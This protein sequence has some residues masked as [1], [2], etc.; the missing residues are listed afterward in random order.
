[1]KSVYQA[2][3]KASSPKHRK[4]THTPSKQQSKPT[5]GGKERA[6]HGGGRRVGY[7]MIP[8]GVAPS[9]VGN[10]RGFDAVLTSLP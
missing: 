6:A 8:L 10:V 7:L 1:M 5:A 2:F 3:P 9:R 4:P